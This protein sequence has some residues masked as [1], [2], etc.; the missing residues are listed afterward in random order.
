MIF[1]TIHK[2]IQDFKSQN[3][4]ILDSFSFN[5]KEILD[6]VVRLYNSQFEKGQYDSEGFRKYFQNIVRNPCDVA[7][8]AI[9]FSTSDINIVPAPGQ[10]YYKAWLLDRDVKHWMK[11]T[12]FAKNLKRVFYELPIFGS[13]VQKKVQGEFHFVDLRNLIVEQTSDTLLQS[14]YVIEMHYMS[15]YEL[16]QMKWDKDKIEEAI[17]MW[18]DT[19][20]PFLRIFERRGDVQESELKEDGDTDKYVRAKFIVFSPENTT[21]GHYDSY[22]QPK[23]G[24]V[25]YSTEETPEEFPYREFHWEKIPGRWLGVGRVEL[26]SDPQIRTNE[27]TNLRVKNSYFTALNIY[28]S[29]DTSAP[30]N[31]VQEV[32]NGDIMNVISEITRIPTEERDLA[33][34]NQEEQAWL[35][36]RDENSMSFDVVRGERLP[37]GTPLGSAQ[38]AAEMTTSYFD[39]IRERVAVDIRKVIQDDVI[40]D[41]LS[42]NQEEHYLRLVGDDFEQITSLLIAERTNKELLKFVMNKGKVPT[43]IQYEAIQGASAEKERSGKEMSMK[44]P[45]DFYKNVEYEVDIVIT[46]EARKMKAQS[47][48]MVTILQAIQQDETILTDPTKRKILSQL[49]SSLGM[50]LADIE[51]SEMAQTGG[52][53]QA[54]KETRGGGISAPQANQ[55]VEQPVE[56]VV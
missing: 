3:S 43:Q 47:S 16:R 6:R 37:A 53:Q 26:N 35:R 18:R 29:R 40:K 9:K 8:K 46:E 2:E 38:I 55:E 15:P 39:D 23:K 24:V 49:L 52:I 17:K 25:L 48:N 50:S 31:L 30:S 42:Q 5:Q 45:N 14:S 22:D 32:A 41:F 34:F 21:H 36:A 10:N 54:A 33:A 13:V 11:K 12:N 51:S 4:K 27:I 28:Q 56:Q 1:D 7:T 19:G 20:E 44:I